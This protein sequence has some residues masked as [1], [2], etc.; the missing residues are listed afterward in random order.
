MELFVRWVQN[1]I[2]HPRF[3]IHSWNDDDSVNE[4]WMY[5]EAL[6]IIRET[7]EFRYRLIP[8]LY[9]LVFEAARS[10]TPIIRPLVYHFQDDPRC[11]TE[12]FDFLLGPNLL[13]ATVFEDGARIRDVYLPKGNHAQ[14]WCDFY[15]GKWYQGGQTITLEAPL[16]RIPLLVRAGG[17]MPMGKVMRYF[18]EKPDDLRQMYIFPHPEVGH[19]RFNLIEDDGVSFDF[20]KG[21]FSECQI[22]VVASRDQISVEVE[23]NQAGFELPYSSIECIFPFGEKRKI[24]STSAFEP[25]Q[26]KDGRSRIALV[27][28]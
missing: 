7:I 1:G 20:L 10:G 23:I 6:P 24:R 11:H 16:N 13:V 25:T 28:D 15:S 26:T 12:S 14:W 2:F 27:L 4:P 5:P 21:G 18:G 8:Y 17:M 19:G 22:Q 9:S 3:T